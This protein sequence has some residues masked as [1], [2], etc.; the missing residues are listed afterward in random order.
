MTKPK[1]INVRYIASSRTVKTTDDD[2]KLADV[3]EKQEETGECPFC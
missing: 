1:K 3:K 2:V